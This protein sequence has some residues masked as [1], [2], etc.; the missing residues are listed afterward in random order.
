MGGFSGG[1][2]PAI[3]TTLAVLE[4][5]VTEL[6]DDNNALV[7]NLFMP[8]PYCLDNGSELCS[9]SNRNLMVIPCSYT[10]KRRT[11]EC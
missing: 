3:M 2:D 4:A 1:G 11:R 9:R 8:L 7:R 5:R 10:D 6:E